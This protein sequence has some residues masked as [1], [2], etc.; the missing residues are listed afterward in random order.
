MPKIASHH[1]PDHP[2]P[3]DTDYVLTK[4]W[5]DDV[6]VQWGG[7]GVVLGEESYMTAFFEAFPAQGFIR[8]EGKTIAE[9][10]A[11]AHA[12]FLRETACTHR[13]GRRG[14]TNGGGKC[15][16]CGG[17]FS[18]SFHPV[19][20][21]GAWRD[22]PCKMTLDSIMSGWLRIRENERLERT[23]YRRRDYL[24]ARA[25][26]IDLPPTPETPMTDEEFLGR[27]DDP[28]RL[29]CRDAVI[30]WLEAGGGDYLLDWERD[31]IFRNVE[32][33]KL[34]QARR[35]ARS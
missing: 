31:A 18:R 12:K 34:F 8:G 24:R 3:N 1:H 25:A 21:L 28:Y 2:L 35:A 17:F 11:D 32:R 19:V 14:Y 5:P 13:I 10:E 16:H 23:K 30:R 7:N 20:R 9:A 33:E 6:S 26:G 27:R 4:D 15:V 22:G 29:A